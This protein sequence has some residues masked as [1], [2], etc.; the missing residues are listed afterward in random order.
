MS[1]YNSHRHLENVSGRFRSGNSELTYGAVVG[2][3]EISS[4]RPIQGRN[5]DH[6]QF[7]IRVDAGTAYQADVN[8]QS[9]DGSD[10]GVYIAEETL[11]PVSAEAPFGEP[12]FGA[13]S[14]AELSYHAIGLTDGNFVALPYTRIEDQLRADLA[15][16]KFVTAYGSMFDDGGA[17]G[18]GVHETHFNPAP[19]ARPNQ[20]GALALHALDGATGKPKRIWYFFKF[21]EDSIG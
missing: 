3:A 6:L 15:T 10:I 9:R 19:P 2:A 1:Y 11:D 21:Q 18:K 16:S 14:G 20:D 8:T 7:Y 5:G 13:D 4:E 12:K 17:N